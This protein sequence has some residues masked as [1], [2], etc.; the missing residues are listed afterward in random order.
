MVH[1]LDVARVAGVSP[2][3]ASRALNNAPHVHIET[4][5]KVLQAAKE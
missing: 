5:Q 4:R 3:T 1:I 2:I